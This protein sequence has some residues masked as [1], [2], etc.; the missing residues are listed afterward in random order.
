MTEPILRQAIVDASRAKKNMEGWKIAAS[1]SLQEKMPLWKT[2][3]AFHLALRNIEALSTETA[4][5]AE[6]KRGLDLGEKHFEEAKQWNGH[7]ILAKARQELEQPKPIG[8][9]LAEL[10]AELDELYEKNRLEDLLD[11]TAERL[12]ILAEAQELERLGDLE[13]EAKTT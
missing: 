10:H 3:G 1:Y 7:R 2:I 9:I 13:R 5:I 8:A 12:E 11:G 4:V 6:A